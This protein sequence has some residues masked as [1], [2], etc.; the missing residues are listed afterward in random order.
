MEWQLQKAAQIDTC[1]KTHCWPSFNLSQG[2]KDVHCH[3]LSIR[4]A[5]KIA[6]LTA[7]LGHSWK[8]GGGGGAKCEWQI[9]KLCVCGVGVYY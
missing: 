2:L 4:Y 9:V 3:I 7:N 5:V 1:T 8:K 6:W